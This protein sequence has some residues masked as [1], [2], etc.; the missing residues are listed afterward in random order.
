ATS[1]QP[2]LVAGIGHIRAEIEYKK[3]GRSFSGLVDVFSASNS[4]EKPIDLIRA[5]V[6]R[7]V[8][9]IKLKNGESKPSTP[10]AV[11]VVPDVSVAH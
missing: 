6:A 10:A 8:T 4:T 3:D 2:V 11:G 1:N 9:E 7:V 5:V